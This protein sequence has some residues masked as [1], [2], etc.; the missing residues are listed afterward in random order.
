[1]AV[2]IDTVYQKVLAL[3]NKEQRGYITPQEF[4][5]FADHAQKEIF[6]QYF[7]DL[8]Q[9]LRVPS[10]SDEYADIPDNLQEKIVIFETNDEVVTLGTT[11]PARLY[12]LGTIVYSAASGVV[13]YDVE[14]EEVQHNELLFINSSPLSRPTVQRPIYTREDFFTIQT[15]PTI[16]TSVSCNYTRQPVVPSWG[17]VVVNEKAMYDPFT[18]TDF[19]L[20]ASEESELVYKILKFAGVTMQKLDIMRA[21]QIQEQSLTQQEKQ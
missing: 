21:G 5:L 6:E 2:S 9:F 7:Y 4:N 3:A 18:T 16:T 19:E 1:M 8:N 13:D 15:Y 12:R 14:I 11:L 20:H 10:N 17:Y